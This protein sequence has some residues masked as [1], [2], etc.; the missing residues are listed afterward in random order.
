MARVVERGDHGGDEVFART[1]D[2]SGDTRGEVDSGKEA[3]SCYEWRGLLRVEEKFGVG[4]Y[5]GH[6]VGLGGWR[7]GSGRGLF[8]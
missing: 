3:L 5:R 8:F 7:G 2:S 6:V 1:V 4:D